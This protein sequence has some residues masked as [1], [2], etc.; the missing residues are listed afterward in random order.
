MNGV[1]ECRESKDAARRE[2]GPDIDHHCGDDR[3]KGLFV[4]S[5]LRRTE[6]ARAVFAAR[7]PD[8]ASR[9]AYFSNLGQRSGEVRRNR[10]VISADEAVALAEAYALLRRV[11]ARLGTN[12]D[13]RA[14]GEGGAV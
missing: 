3:K 14:T 6:N 12:A 10:I 5:D 2:D 13:G 8:E 1:I 11:V 7:F 9:R 4:M